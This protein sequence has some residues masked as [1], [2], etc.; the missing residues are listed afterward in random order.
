MLFKSKE[1]IVRITL[2]TFALSPSIGWY[3]KNAIQVQAKWEL[4]LIR[5][6]MFYY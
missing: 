5:P 2:C 1:N 4:K 3:Q 6:G